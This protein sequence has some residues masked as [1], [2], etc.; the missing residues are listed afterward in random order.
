MSPSFLIYWHREA[1]SGLPRLL[2]EEVK[3]WG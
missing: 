2:L 1:L 3:K